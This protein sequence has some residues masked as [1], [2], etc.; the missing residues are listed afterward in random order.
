MTTGLE[1]GTYNSTTGEIDWENHYQ[2]T[3]MQQLVINDGLG[4]GS[5]SASW[6][7]RYPTTH[8]TDDGKEL[9]LGGQVF[10]IW[11]EDEKLFE[12]TIS[13]PA[14][15]W[16]GG[17]G[18]MEIAY[19]GESYVR[20]LDR[21]LVVGKS[22][23]EE[24][25]RSRILW[26]LGE[27]AE[28]FTDPSHMKQGPIIP[29][30]DYDYEKVS[31]AISSIANQVNY[32]WYV[33]YNKRIHFFDILEHDAPTTAINIDE[34][35]FPFTPGTPGDIEVIHDA[36]GIANVIILKDFSSMDKNVFSEV[37]IADGV[38]TFFKL[39]LP[40][41]DVAHTRVFIQPEGTNPEWKERTV[42]EDPLGVEGEADIHG[43]EG[44]AY[45][46]TFNWG[47]RFPDRGFLDY[48]DDG[49]GDGSKDTGGKPGAGDKVRTDYNPEVP[50]R[51]VVVFDEDS[52]REMQRRHGG[53][54]EH[55]MVISVSDFRVESDNPVLALGNLILR[56]KAWPITHGTFITRTQNYGEWQPGQTFTI[57]SEK[58][59]IFDVRQWVRSDYNDKEPVRVWVDN[60]D[61]E[62]E[63]HNDGIW[64]R[65]RIS[66]TS[67]P[68]EVP[69]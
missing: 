53:S 46:C 62:F 12:G 66:F 11:I 49:M 8:V 43:Q 35:P 58:R 18:A 3:D 52:I 60:V 38:S 44:M 65:N 61:R 37:Q 32:L 55:Q 17:G 48:G 34:D 42:I 16:F 64:E 50:E 54:G 4:S 63:V 23:P 51:I 25:A 33:D 5:D 56:R 22:R 10:R 45:L 41:W 59:D 28:D 9:P 19:S 27:F 47:V 26:I 21:H 57:V 30:S 40:P 6:S 31:S 13:S 69:G 68:W 1:V 29:E 36:S 24:R 67:Q 2:F 20:L 39:S 7:M 15:R 14:N